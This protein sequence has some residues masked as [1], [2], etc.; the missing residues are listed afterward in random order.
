M[1]IKRI[2]SS[3]FRQSSQVTACYKKMAPESEKYAI[4]SKKIKT[5][6]TLQ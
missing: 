3:V 4:I 6:L 5:T 1:L 2:F